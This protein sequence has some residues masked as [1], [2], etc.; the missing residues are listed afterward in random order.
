M[1]IVRSILLSL[2]FSLA[3][4]FVIGTIIRLKLDPPEFYI[5]AL[6]EP[7]AG[8]ASADSSIGGAATP[9]DVRHARAR[10]LEAGEYE[11]QI[12]QAVH[13]A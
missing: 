12:R 8:P 5:G 9:L 10:I 6:F 13:V 7:S 4:G 1:R 2:L 11:E 3:V